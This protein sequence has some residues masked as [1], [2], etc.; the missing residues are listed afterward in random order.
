MKKSN[1]YKASLT[2][3]AVTAGFIASYPFSQNFWGGL[4]ASGCQAAMV[5]GLADWFAVTALFRRPL[6]ISFRTSLISRNRE[7]IFRDLV[8]MVQSRLLTKEHIVAE[9]E[10]HYFAEYLLDYLERHG[11]KDDVK[12]VLRKVGNDIVQ[13]LEPTQIGIIIEKL[14]KNHAARIR[15]APVLIQAM[16]WSLRSGYAERLLDFLIAEMINLS[17]REETG[18]LMEKLVAEAL[19]AYQQKN[20][21]RQFISNLLDISPG[22]LAGLAQE[23]LIGFLERI[24]AVDHPLRQTYAQWIEALLADLQA[25]EA[26]QEQLETWKL[27]FIAKVDIQAV[28]AGIIEFLRQKDGGTS[29]ALRTFKWLNRQIDDLTATFRADEE[30]QHKL[31]AG[32]KYVIA[33]LLDK[34]HP[35]IGVTVQTALAK[36]TDEMLVGFIENKVGNDLQM[37]RINGS[38][39]GGLVGMI[40]FLVTYWI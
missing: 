23:Q 11:G 16:E 26:L 6:G 21:G 13:K 22:K 36:Y 39:I 18:E 5:G 8:D 4:I 17:Q 12:S 28:I 25:D 19:E 34:Y 29:D 9:L 40:L 38:V 10:R 35:E 20:T 30:Q 14:L 24:Q 7:R 3:G 1:N 37:I 32:I 2:L 31:D 15:L 33:R 27:E